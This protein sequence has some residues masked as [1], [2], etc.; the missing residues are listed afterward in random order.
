MLA[1]SLQGLHLRVF[2]WGKKY[3]KSSTPPKP[4]RLLLGVV[5]RTCRDVHPECWFPPSV[6]P[7]PCVTG[8]VAPSEYLPVIGLWPASPLA[9]GGLSGDGLKPRSH[10]L[11]Y[12]SR[13]FWPEYGRPHLQCLRPVHLF[14]PPVISALSARGLARSVSH[15][16]LFSSTQI[17]FIL[18]S[19]LRT[20]RSCSH[21]PDSHARGPK[22][23][24]ELQLDLS[25]DLRVPGSWHPILSP[26]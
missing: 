6:T 3:R 18:H 9:S 20:R 2:F 4:Q 16:G 17:H 14:P 7:G 21:P 24:L 12:F 19:F 11:P 5:H 8:T 26:F 1:S 23:T 13:L 22:C 25:A 15:C 10:R